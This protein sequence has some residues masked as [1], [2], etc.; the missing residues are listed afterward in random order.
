MKWGYPMNFDEEARAFDTAR[1]KERAQVI[2]RRIRQCVGE[3]RGC[4]ME[5]GCGTGLIGLELTDLF[6]SIIFL[7]SSQG[8]ID[9]LRRKIAHVPNTTAICLDLL[10]ET[11]PRQRFD[12]I[13]SSMVLHHIRD[14]A[15]IL[16]ILHGLLNHGGQL[17]IV[18][19]DKD[20]GRFHAA[21]LDFDGHHGFGQAEMTGLL[22]GAGFEKIEMETFYRSSKEIHGEEVSYSLFIASAVKP[23]IPCRVQEVS[24]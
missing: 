14:T 20:D 1:R 2:A 16:A 13:F 19:L 7:D 22:R 6:S 12:C 9:E 11:P 23:A 17:I 21:E 4:A 10:E 15:R 5:F 24:T 18:D 3:A 8:M